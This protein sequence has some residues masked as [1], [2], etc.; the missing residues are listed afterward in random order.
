MKYMLG[1]DP[2]FFLKQNGKHVS[3]EGIVGGAEKTEQSLLC[4]TNPYA[5]TKA[6][7]EMVV[8]SYK[9]SFGLP[10]IISRGNNVYGPN[11]YPEK[12]IPK[13]IGLLRDG[14]KLTI[15][16]KGEQIRSFLW[17]DDVSR[18]FE[19]MLVKGAV[20]EVYNIGSCEEYSV[21][22]VAKIM[23][24]LIHGVDVDIE[25]YI[26]YMNDRPFNDMRYFI[27]NDKLYALGWQ[28]KVS[29]KDGLTMLFGQVVI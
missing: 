26:E 11:Q 16:G 8:S 1:C 24:E 27:S 3:A 14:K 12:L 5:A 2:E 10:V 23:L 22:D 9:H 7:A 19:T 25:K 17:V 6:G 20:G 15:A 13:W 28:P 29:F 21:M 4:P 18:A